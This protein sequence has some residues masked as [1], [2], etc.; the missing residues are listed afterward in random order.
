MEELHQAR[1]AVRMLKS[2]C[3]DLGD[4]LADTLG[5]YNAL[6]TADRDIVQAQA[7][8]KDRQREL[9][10]VEQKR[11]ALHIQCEEYRSTLSQLQQECDDFDG[12]AAARLIAERSAVRNQLE[13][14]E[15]LQ[16]EVEE[17]EQDDKVTP[18]TVSPEVGQQ[19]E[20]DDLNKFLRERES[21]AESVLQHA[22]ELE[23]VQQELRD[24]ET[25]I[26]FLRADVAEVEAKLKQAREALVEAQAESEKRLEQLD[27]KLE[28]T[29]LERTAL[30][31][32]LWLKSQGNFDQNSFGS[33]PNSYT[34][35]TELDEE[36]LVAKRESLG[37][38]SAMLARC[39]QERRME[40][41]RLTAELR[42]L[43]VRLRTSA[44]KSCCAATCFCNV[45]Y[46]AVSLVSL[47][48]ARS[49][50]VRAAPLEM[51]LA[52][53]EQKS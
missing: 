3:I 2:Q 11:A 5:E 19:N 6:K 12:Q 32:E 1:A 49:R 43:E 38:Q 40:C 39:I 37:E 9:Q 17:E 44:S 41:D 36:A 24:R 14:L 53:V 18:E 22:E 52:L 29:D 50:P 30:E 45:V 7:A 13:Q 23:E 4:R 28:G 15:E 21:L 51:E 8:V 16:L 20:A 25:H 47:C 26:E 35:E 42:A 34:E 10:Q 27:S 46:E 33:L 31:T 48:C